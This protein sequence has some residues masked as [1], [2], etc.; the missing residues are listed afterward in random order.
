MRIRTALLLY[1]FVCILV[2]CVQT[3]PQ[4]QPESIAKP[5]SHD[6]EIAS[7]GDV[8][9]R[10]A[11]VVKGITTEEAIAIMGT[12][13]ADSGEVINKK[14]KRPTRVLVYDFPDTGRRLLVYCVEGVV[15]SATWRSL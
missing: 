13:D 8:E 7:F 2:G 10:A 4:R 11:R 3:S 12:P 15:S 1:G 14:S 6:N 9:Q 5:R